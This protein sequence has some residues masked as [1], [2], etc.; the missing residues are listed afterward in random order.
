MIEFYLKKRKN[1]VGLVL[2]V[3]AK[4]RWSKEE[5]QILHWTECFS[6]PLLLVVSK[7]DRLN[8]KEKAAA[9]RHFGALE[10]TLPSVWLSVRTGQGISELERSIFENF[11]RTC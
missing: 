7:I 5:S 1:L 2:I 3:D 4:R 11:V 9:K 8:Q 6:L 10:L